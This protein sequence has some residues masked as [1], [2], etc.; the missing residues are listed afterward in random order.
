MREKPIPGIA[1]Q[2]VPMSSAEALRS[3]FLEAILD[4]WYAAVSLE[5]GE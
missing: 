5:F 4:A 1:H 2:R 3:P